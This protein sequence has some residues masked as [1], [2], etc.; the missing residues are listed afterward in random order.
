M[1]RV[2]VDG[3]AEIMEKLD[4]E[5]N[6]IQREPVRTGA[7]RCS[8]KTSPESGYSRVPIG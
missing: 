4:G 5:I 7:C 1:R 2:E 6:S 8:R 3:L